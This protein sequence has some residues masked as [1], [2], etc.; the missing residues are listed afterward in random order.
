MVSHFDVVP[1]G[2]GWT[3]D[4]FNPTIVGEK[5]YGRGTTDDKGQYGFSHSKYNIHGPN[6]HVEFKDLETLYKIIRHLL[7]KG[8]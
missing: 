8:I 4:P 6:E 2:E 7:E 3:Y 1:A 5:L